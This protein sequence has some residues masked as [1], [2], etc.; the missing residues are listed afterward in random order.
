MKNK[1][2]KIASIIMTVMMVVAIVGAATVTGS[3]FLDL[4]NIARY[5]LIGFAVVFGIVAVI[6]ARYGWK[7]K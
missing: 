5:F 3:G 7:S 2:F 6:T 1:I 4:S